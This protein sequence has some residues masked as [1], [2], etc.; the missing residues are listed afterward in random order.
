MGNVSVPKTNHVVYQQLTT[1]NV[2]LRITAGGM[3]QLYVAG[4]D[5]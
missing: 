2:H 3:L 4:N 1:E 5:D